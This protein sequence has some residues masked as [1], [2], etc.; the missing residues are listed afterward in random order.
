M[1]T[2]G[3]ERPL[4]MQTETHFVQKTFLVHSNKK[5]SQ[6]RFRYYT[7]KLRKHEWS[8]QTATN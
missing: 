3:T 6:K 4:K 1:E 2:T 5:Y 7:L 8:H